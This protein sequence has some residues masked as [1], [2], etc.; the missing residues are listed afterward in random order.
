MKVNFDRL[1]TKHILFAALVLA[2]G[3]MLI[4][5][6]GQDENDSYKKEI[7]EYRVSKDNHLKSAEDSPIDKKETFNGLNYYEPDRTYKVE[8]T[9]KLIDQPAGID[10]LRNDGRKD[11]YIDFAEATFH[12]HGKE[13]KVIL[14]KR[15]DEQDTKHLFF[16]FTDK[17]NGEETYEGGRYIDLEYSG[18]GKLTIDFNLAYNPYCVYN[19]RYSCPIPPASNFIET[20]IKAGEKKPNK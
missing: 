10:I 19:Y 13:H 4:S 16:P 5:L 18:K 11:K 8:A 12:L 14:L 1:K 7:N 6:F 9:L 15:T 20:E 3:I 2:L 17:T